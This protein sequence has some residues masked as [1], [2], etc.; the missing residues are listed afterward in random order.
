MIS[1]KNYHFQV[2]LSNIPRKHNH[3]EWRKS[4][5]CVIPFTCDL[6]NGE[7]K[8]VE[9]IPKNSKNKLSTSLIILE[10]NGIILNPISTT[11][12]SKGVLHGILKDYLPNWEYNIGDVIINDDKSVK[13]IDRKIINGKRSY[14]ILCLNC[15]F[16]SGEHY[17]LVS[18]IFKPEYW[19]NEWR[20]KSKSTCPCCCKKV[21]VQG[22]N[23][24]ATTDSWMVKYFANKYDLITHTSQSQKKID[25]ICPNC[26]NHKPQIISNLYKRKYM[27]CECSDNISF[28]NKLAFYTLK[29]I[30]VLENYQREYSPK[31]VKPYR[32]DNYFEY[33]GQSYIIEMDGNVGHGNMQYRSNKR[34]IDGLQ[35]DLIK[36]KKAFE[37]N[38]KLYR[39]D[40]T[41]TNYDIIYQN[42]CNV[43]SNILGYVPVLNKEAIISL[44]IKNI[45][46]DVCNYY[47][48]ISNNHQEICNTYKINSTTLLRYLEQG[49]KYGWCDYK[50]MT[51]IKNENKIKVAELYQ[52]NLSLTEIASELKLHY[53]TVKKYIIEADSEGLCVFNSQLEHENRVKIGLEKRINFFSKT[54]YMYDMNYNFIREYKSAT[55]IERNSLNDFGIILK[56]RA[57]GRVC[58]KQ[59]PQYKGYIFTYTPINISQHDCEGKVTTC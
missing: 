20:L 42:L 24:I 51:V 41:S 23:D 45:I 7:F 27:S 36:N 34:D 17:S 54:V 28:P 38:I 12:L 26:G 43:V 30:S 56:S 6:F 55:E 25:M 52:S 33:Q 1:N 37:N 3:I 16:N 22:I 29:S 49:S 14:K 48:K 47:S 53:D 11:M 19:I 5:N 46:K 59:R 13:I 58:L 40:C 2:D 31:W 9:H 18:N 8:V 57:I 39:V 35:R 44:S 32:Y 4:K 21:I 10:Y 15:G 50:K